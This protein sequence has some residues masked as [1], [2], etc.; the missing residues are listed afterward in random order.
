MAEEKKQNKI[1]TPEFRVAFPSVFQPRSF[2]GGDAKYTVTMLF[3]KDADLGILREA[4][5]QAMLERWPSKD[6]RPKKLKNPFLDGDEVEWDGFEGCTFI[7]ATSKFAPGIIDRAKKPITTEERFYAGCYARATVNAFA[8]D[9]AGNR[10]VA[11]GLQNL[12]FLRDGEPFS[13]RTKA[14][15]DFDSLPDADDGESASGEETPFDE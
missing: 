11:F 8:Y 15:D 7:R 5:K 14:E 13:G 10:G 6:K 4:A 3:P 9:T 1:M 2:D 12:Q